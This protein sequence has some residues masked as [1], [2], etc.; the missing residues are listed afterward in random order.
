MKKLD[1]ISGMKKLSSFYLKEFTNEQLSLWYEMFEE[2]PEDIFNQAIKEISK[3]NKYM[4][5][6][7]ELYDKCSFLNKNN[8][9]NIA[10]YMYQDGYFHRG[11]KRLS[12][13]QALRN[14]DK[15]IM[16]LEKGIIPS[17]LK[18]DIQDYMKKY[19][20]SQIQNQERLKIEC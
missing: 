16:W 3:E 13:E 5:N 11:V 19:K 6:A 7:S 17:F 14:L 18:E 4:P 15:T 9:M 20:Q 1:F 12:D 8:L 2:I 10:N